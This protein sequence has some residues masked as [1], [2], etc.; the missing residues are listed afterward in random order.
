MKTCQRGHEY[1]E[2]RKQCPVCRAESNKAWL[3]A[4]PD[5]QKAY[6]LENKEHIA[7][8]SKAWSLANPDKH[9]E[10]KK[11]WRLENKDREREN[12]NNYQRNRKATDPLFKLACNIRS[13]I[14][15]SL[16]N[17]GY[18][19]NSRTHHILGCS[20]EHF[21][22]HLIATAITNYGY[23]LECESYHIDHNDPV[24]SATTKEEILTLNRYTNFQ[25]LT[26]EH[27]RAKGDQLDWT[28]PT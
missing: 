15:K 14:H 5:H 28:L 3:A 27:N 9:R 25:L 18:S 7:A 23:W 19:K 20:F 13:L 1:E 10:L 26:P 22:Q 8:Y 11:A 17:N 21:Q 16:R 24:S 4:N 12:Q 6:Y 2:S